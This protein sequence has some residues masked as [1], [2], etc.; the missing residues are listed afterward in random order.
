[1]LGGHGRRNYKKVKAAVDQAD[2]MKWRGRETTNRQ[3]HVWS[4]DRTEVDRK[5]TRNEQDNAELEAQETA[6]TRDGS[7]RWPRKRRES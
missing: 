4:E 5:S 2:D 1:M 6:T 7:G 3:V